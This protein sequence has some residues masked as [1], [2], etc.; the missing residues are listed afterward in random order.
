MTNVV[1][2]AGVDIGRDFLDMAIAPSGVFRR[3]ANAPRGIASLIGHLRRA[4]VVRVVLEAIGVYAARLTAAL[5]EGGFEVGVV[6]PRRIRAWRTPRRTG[7]TRISW[8]ALL[9]RCRRPFARFPMTRPC[10]CARSRRVAVSSW[11]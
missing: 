10:V 3:V 4:G 7:W 5:R 1:C 11:R 8:R 6:D 2:A 9:W